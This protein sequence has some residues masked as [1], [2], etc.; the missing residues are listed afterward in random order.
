MVT[1]SRG[2]LHLGGMD[3]TTATIDLDDENE[4]PTIPALRVASGLARACAPVKSGDDEKPRR[5]YRP[6]S[7]HV[8]FDHTAEGFF[9][10]A[11]DALAT[12][13]ADATDEE[14]SQ[15]WLAERRRELA[16]WVGTIIALCVV[17]LIAS[18][19]QTLT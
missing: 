13:A 11:H 16:P 6:V 9:A 14:V 19:L 4:R 12:A 7:G 3:T 5:R 10:S 8:R 18:A 2:V 17:M 1:A 15:W